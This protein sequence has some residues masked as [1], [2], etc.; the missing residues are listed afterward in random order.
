MIYRIIIP[1]IIFLIFPVVD[2]FCFGSKQ[3]SKEPVLLN[4]TQNINE[5]SPAQA[6]I[7]AELVMKALFTAYPR[8]I[9]KVEF[10]GGDWAVLLRGTWFYY[11]QSKML[12]EHLL[13][14]AADYSPQP[15]YNYQKELPPWRA[16]SPEESERYRNMADSRN[17]N[18]LRRSSH[19]FDTLWQASNRTEADQR[20]KSIRFLGKFV[21]VHYSIME[22][23][24][25]VEYEIL[26]T[27]KTDPQVQSWINSLS[28]VGGWSWRDIA[29]TQSRSFHSYGVAI[30][31]LP[32]SLG[33]RE[34]YWLTASNKRQ[35]WWNISYNERYH[36]PSSVISAFEKYGFIW[37]GKWLY[38]DTMHFEYRPEIL[39]LSQ[40][41]PEMRR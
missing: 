20:M 28:T 26:T 35:D 31:I 14:N 24:S 8:Q 21:T 2:V 15:F 22:E 10:R 9:E 25:L 4:D 41:P 11:A 32:K 34:T 13:P 39:F 6:K 23:L 7:R 3:A 18:P 38:F 27:A 29:N 36:P 37:G 16:P 30:D 12:P 33:G 40:M 17:R 19:F 1:A 5:L